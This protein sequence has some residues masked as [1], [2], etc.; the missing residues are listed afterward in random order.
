MN[1]LNH[2]IKQKIVNAIS[3]YDLDGNPVLTS[4]KDEL[5]IENEKLVGGF[6]TSITTF[7]Q[8]KNFAS[9]I[10]LESENGEI[11]VIKKTDSFIGALR[12]KDT[13][14]LTLQESELILNEYLEQMEQN[15]I[16]NP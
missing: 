9:S 11:H 1:V 15:L 5:E 3:L 2:L 10:K 4:D 16:S 7:A 8:M 6:Y 13:L 12:W 14:Q